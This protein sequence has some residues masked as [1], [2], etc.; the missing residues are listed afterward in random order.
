MISALLAIIQSCNVHNKY[1]YYI[2]DSSQEFGTHSWFSGKSGYRK[3]S[4]KRA[5]KQMTRTKH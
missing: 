3:R 4:N 5:E 1:V 2:H